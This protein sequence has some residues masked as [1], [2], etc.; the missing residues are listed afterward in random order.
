LPDVGRVDLLFPKQAPMAEFLL[1]W[2][3]KTGMK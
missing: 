3:A 1:A 2:L